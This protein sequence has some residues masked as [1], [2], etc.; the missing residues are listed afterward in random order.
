MN[1]PIPK[2]NPI[3]YIDQKRIDFIMY[4]ADSLLKNVKGDPQAQHF[5]V[6]E[7]S[8]L[9]GFK[10]DNSSQTLYIDEI[11]KKYKIP[12]KA[13]N[14]AIKE[15]IVL[16]RDKARQKEEI[17]VIIPKGIDANEFEK[18]GF[19]ESNHSYH[20]RTKEGVQQFSNFV[21]RPL[22]HID[23]VNDSLRIYELTNEHGYKIVADF[24]MNEMTSITAF[25][26]HIE[27]RGNFLFWGGDSQINKL[28]L[29][30]YKETTTCTKLDNL[31]WQREGFFA[32][33]NGISQED[34]FRPVDDYGRI[35]FNN[36]NYYIPA[37]SKVYLNDK[38]V[39][40]DERKFRY[41]PNNVSMRDWATQ[42]ISVFKDNAII[43]IAFWIAALHRDIMLNTFK[44]FPL[45]NLFGPKGT[46]KSQLAVSLSCLFGI[47]Q[48]PFNIHNG[49]KAGLAE[50]VQ[51]FKNSIAWIDEYKNNIDFD[52][53]ETLKSIYDA[54]G[55]NRLNFEKGRRKET[56]QVNQAVI[57]SGQEMPTADVALFSRM[58]F[59][60]FNQ[61]EFS[62]TEKKNYD[63]LK[64]VENKGLSHLSAQIIQY[65]KHFEENYY[66]IYQS[67]L[68]DFAS[69]LEG[70]NIEDRIMRS[71]VMIA[72]SFRTI[73]SEVDFP[74]NYDTLKKAGISAL[75]SQQSQMK[76]SNEVSV[77]WQSF[78]ALA[79]DN[80]I[81][82][83]WDFRIDLKSDLNLKNKTRIINTTIN[84]LQIRFNDV[85]SKYRKF[86]R[87][88]GI[89]PL[90][91]TT[92]QYYLQN[93]PYYLGDSKATKFKI[94]RREADNIVTDTK[95]T[96]AM[97]FDYDQLSDLLSID[98]LKTSEEKYSN[99]TNPEI[100]KPF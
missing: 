76:S 24:D 54:I 27:S 45:L 31:G 21:M 83:N 71:M 52:K 18:W 56:T 58:I 92:L 85:V 95:N 23:S 16:V 88:S 8:R 50:H 15:S 72:A 57:L 99:N 82:E 36:N 78:E 59:C 5:A 81:I 67:T 44:N 64:K 10:K 55:R 13:F 79:S 66:N 30:L 3:Q 7:L 19:Y 87:A 63:D 80:E 68:S 96:T 48:T 41:I 2:L 51:Q 86:A 75:K 62:S 74:F 39:F 6:N 91:N 42:L 43:G 61:S 94:T 98:L 35:S 65:R 22:F 77:F 25:K 38:S 47:Q 73:S 84:V 29:K 90:P 9:I 70:C 34:G 93:S 100:D 37:F 32:W 69:E 28:K 1:I 26:R 33:A 49:T 20:F 46:G 60:R 14:D 4:R 89:T 11:F 53:V 12:K 17:A 40:L 97:C